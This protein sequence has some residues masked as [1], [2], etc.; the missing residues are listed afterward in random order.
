[1]GSSQGGRQKP[2]FL[3]VLYRILLV[4]LVLVVFIIIGGTLF[5]IFNPPSGAPPLAPQTVPAGTA[6][7]FTGIGRLRVSTSDLQPGVVIINVAFPYYPED[8][9]F[10]EELALRVGDFRDIINTYIASYTIEDLL[11]ADEEQIKSDLL[12][13]LNAVLRLGRI[14]TLYFT[15]FMVIG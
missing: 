2:G 15:D 13:E 5:S 14:E 10:T 12:R 9:A 8:L 4:C 3:A 6:E 11:G 7:I 1:M